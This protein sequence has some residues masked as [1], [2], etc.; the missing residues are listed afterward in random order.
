MTPPEKKPFT[1]RPAS[2]PVTCLLTLGSTGAP[3]PL[4]FSSNDWAD[5][6]GSSIKSKR[7]RNALERRSTKVSCQAL[8]APLAHGLSRRMAWSEVLHGGRLGICDT[9]GDVVEQI[10]KY[11]PTHL[12]GAPRFYSLYSG[13]LENCWRGLD[14]DSWPSAVRP[15]RGPSS[16]P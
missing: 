3:K 13:K 5:W 4:K 6:C 7:E 15:C 16:L 9:R 10:R 2:E 1:K 12:S 14:S 11:A 8:V